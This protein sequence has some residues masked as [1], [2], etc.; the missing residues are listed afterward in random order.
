[1]GSILVGVFEIQ[2]ELLG[3]GSVL[4]EY[5]VCVEFDTG[6]LYILTSGLGAIVQIIT[7]RFNFYILTLCTRS[8]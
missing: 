5:M 3:Q 8:M 2:D 1:M 4:V 7:T 6:F